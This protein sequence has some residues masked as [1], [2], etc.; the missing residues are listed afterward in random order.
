MVWKTVHGSDFWQRWID[1]YQELR[2]TVYA[3]TN[4][5]VKID[6]YANQVRQATTR[7]Y[8]RWRGSGGSDTSPR[9]GFRSGDG[10]SYTF[11]SPGTWQGEVNFA[12]YWFSNRVDF[13]DSQFLNPP[14]FSSGGG[15]VNPGAGLAITASTRETNTTIYY[16][17]DGTDPRLPGGGIS[18]KALS[19]V[20]TVSLTLSNNARV[21]A[22]NW[23]ATHHNLTGANNPPL[24]SSWSG[25]T[26]A[27]FIVSTPALAITELM[28][29]PAPPTFGTN[30]NDQFEFI[31]LK[32]VG[33]SAL[34][35]V[36]THFTNGIQF[37]FTA[38][39]DITNLNPGQYLVLVAN[40]AA[41]MSRYPSVTNIAGQYSGKLSNGG[42]HLQLEGALSETIADFHFNNSW[43][44]TTDGAGFSLVIRDETAPSAA[45][46]N[47]ATWRAS[48]AL[49]GSPGHADLVPANIPTVVINEAL[50]HTD[51]PTVDSVELYNPT[52]SPAAIGGW[53]LT[54]DRTQPMKYRI[55]DGTSVAAGGYIIFNENQFNNNGSNSFS[56]S[57]L[58]EEIYLSSGDGT[59]LTGY[60]HGFKFGAQINGITFGRYISSDG[61]EHFVSQKVTTLGTLNSG[62]KVGPVVISELMYAPPPFG[63]DADTVDEYVELRNISDQA[64]P[65]YSA[66]YPTNAW[67]VGGA[68]QFTF[69]LG[70]TLAPWSFLVLVSFDPVHDPASLS[71]FRSQYKLGN[72]VVIL[73]PYQGHLG[74]QDESLALYQP[75]NPELPT[76]LHPGLVPYVL[77]EEVH[78]SPSVPWPTTADGT[79]NSL[80]RISCVS[81]ADDPANWQAGSPTP[82]ALNPGALNVDSDHDGAPDELEFLA[83][84][85]P[86]NSQDFL[87]IRSSF[88]R[89]RQ[90][91]P[92]IHW[93]RR[94]Q[95]HCRKIIA[96]RSL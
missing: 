10:F 20:N 80:Q 56:L 77:V 67:R 21:F 69:P 57:S 71:W 36:G 91:R 79:G 46:T 64:V 95:L 89:W 23:N 53:F 50:T 44:P 58:G 54:D 88:S 11:P 76:S 32:N 83:G 63:L 18:P 12:K 2:K 9:S 85:D 47:P 90:L 27:S 72:D 5:N 68:V 62:P 6:G 22:R 66:L 40:R 92:R 29:N 60:Q 70:T 94:S 16:T 82:G 37:V 43:Y 96:T 4:L 55:P 13:M 81:F 26:V 61:I 35:L 86:A 14:L 24:S 17:L 19:S 87:E 42:E 65:L 78:Y 49:G 30:D 1:R 93:P 39:S 38:T 48:S 8:A 33:S 31:E 25:P 75:D 45:W 7:E 34:N 74:N 15:R 41:F 73:G 3:I 59:Q 28:Y 84:T 52:A 51:L